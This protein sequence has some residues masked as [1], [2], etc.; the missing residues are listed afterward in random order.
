MFPQ[1]QERDREDSYVRGQHREDAQGHPQ[2]GAG[3][4]E[5]AA[6]VDS[7]RSISPR[8]NSMTEIPSLVVIINTINSMNNIFIFECKPKYNVETLV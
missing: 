6:R 4:N 1:T 3:V 5:A 7:L 2:D 8:G